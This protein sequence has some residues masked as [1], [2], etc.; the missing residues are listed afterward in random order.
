[1]IGVDIVT[2][3]TLS[4]LSLVVTEVAIGIYRGAGR[5][6]RAISSVIFDGTGQAGGTSN[7]VR[8]T[9]STVRNS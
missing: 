1:M 4:A 6:N 7:V 8:G 9:S 5:A 3:F 2:N